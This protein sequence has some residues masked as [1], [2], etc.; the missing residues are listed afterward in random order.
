MGAGYPIAQHDRGGA[1][2][3]DMTPEQAA[4]AMDALL[5]P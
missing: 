3:K 4:T 1:V 2:P 5:R